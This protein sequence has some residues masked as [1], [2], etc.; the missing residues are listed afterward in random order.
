[1][2]TNYVQEG[3]VLDL[4]APRAQWTVGGS[5]KAEGLGDGVVVS[6]SVAKELRIGPG[7]EVVLRVEKSGA[8]PR[9]VPLVSDEDRTVAARLK[10][11]AVA[12]DS[13][14]GRFDLQANQAAPLNVLVP[15]TWLAGQVG[16]EGEITSVL[17]LLN[18]KIFRELRLHDP[19]IPRPI[20]PL[21][22]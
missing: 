5:V 12:G 20:T 14:F 21:L 2:A 11:Q 9:D 1:M 18:W 22:V 10:V 4:T 13:A 17:I 15:L 19:A 7:D 16:Q 8:M 6:E 3:K